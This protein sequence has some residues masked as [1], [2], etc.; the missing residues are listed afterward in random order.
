MKKNIRTLVNLFIKSFTHPFAKR[1]IFFTFYRIIRWQIL[2]RI[3]PVLIESWV[4]DIKV[5]CKKGDTGF[6]GNLYFGL[7]E[8]EDMIFMLHLLDKDDVFLDIGSNL[9]SYSLLAG[10]ICESKTFSLEPSPSSFNRMIKNIELN[11]FENVTCMNIGAGNENG[12]FFMTDSKGP[13]NHLVTESDD[14]IKVEIKRIDDI[15]F[16]SNPT[17]IKI[18]TE[19]T[20]FEVIR[21]GL[22]VLDSP[23]M[24]GLLAEINGNN[25]RY[26]QKT[27][28]MIQ[29]LNNLGYH[30]YR[31][32]YSN[33]ELHKMNHIKTNGNTLFIKNYMKAS[34]K[35]K[36]YKPNQLWGKDI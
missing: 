19:G 26:N 10:G 7:H 1:N 29:F 32:D 31:Y 27:N 21:G 9:G 16:E 15:K 30:A 13:E 11:N 33:K 3:R 25:L 5:I 28:E 20:E 34:Q 4:N 6:T 22:K 24:I 17:F 35:I 14:A 2:S 36:D 23:E 12:S 8:Y 18:D